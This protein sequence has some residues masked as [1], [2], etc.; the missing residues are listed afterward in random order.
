VLTNARSQILQSRSLSELITPLLQA[1]AKSFTNA[2][3][4]VNRNSTFFT[5]NLSRPPYAS[6][7]TTPISAL[8]TASAALSLVPESHWTT[9]THKS[10]ISS[11]DGA[12]AILENLNT[13]STSTEDAEKVRVSADKT[14]KKEL[15]HYLRWALSA[16]APGPGIPE[17]MVILGKEETVR[18]LR[19]ARELTVGKY[20]GMGSPV[21]ARQAMER[22]QAKV[23]AKT[24]ESD[25]DLDRSW[26]GSLAP[27]S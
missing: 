26:M 16:G 20:K 23:K 18:R 1:D 25:Q 14:F 7:N 22:A 21:A 13:N 27:K 2:T 17:T 4:F 8:H 10:N 9:R 12:S 11:Y 15:Y 24:S 6:T 3:E 19:E 5:T